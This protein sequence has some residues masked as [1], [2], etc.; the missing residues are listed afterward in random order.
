MSVKSLLLNEKDNV[1]MALENIPKASSVSVLY[2]GQESKTIR[3]IDDI[4]SYHKFALANLEE[5]ETIIKYGEM[6]GTA[7]QNIK[8]GEYVHTHNVRGF[9]V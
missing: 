2:R 6:I 8:I 7:T 1:A 4:E 9:K 3:T 5:G